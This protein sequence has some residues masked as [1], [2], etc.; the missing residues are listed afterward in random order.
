MPTAGL[1]TAIP[2]RQ[3]PQSQA[4][5]SAVVEIGTL[6][7]VIVTKIDTKY[8]ADFTMLGSVIIGV[9]EIFAA[10]P[11]NNK[12]G[13]KFSI[14]SEICYLLRWGYINISLNLHTYILIYIHIN[15]HKQIKSIFYSHAVCIMFQ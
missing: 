5:D 3:Q 10:K 13:T 15:I 8:S 11:K 9:Y 4:L 2:A 1:E 6:N 7:A 14:F 12:H